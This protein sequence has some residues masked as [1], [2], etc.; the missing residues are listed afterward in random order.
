M[1]LPHISL[2][3][4]ENELFSKILPK[5]HM[6]STHCHLQYLIMAVVVYFI[7]LIAFLTHY[8]CPHIN[9][10]AMSFKGKHEHLAS[11][12]T[13]L[14]PSA[15]PFFLCRRVSSHLW[16]WCTGGSH[17]W[18]HDKRNRG[19]SWRVVQPKHWTLCITEEH[20]AGQKYFI[21]FK[22]YN[23]CNDFL[24]RTWHAYFKGPHIVYF[25][26]FVLMA[27][28]LFQAMV[29]TIDALSTCIRHVCTFE[30]A[31]DLAAVRSVPA[32]VLRILK[33]TFRHCKV[34]PYV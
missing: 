8:L 16:L 4:L 29:Q 32:Y 27:R 11:Y 1:F 2:S 3:E 6:A 22:I 18:Q 25:L 12:F 33:E 23:E 20:S 30:E 31:P 26:T 14:N 15:M 28:S 5:V 7:T 34:S 19:P 9:K 13:S 21:H 24:M 10:C 17:V